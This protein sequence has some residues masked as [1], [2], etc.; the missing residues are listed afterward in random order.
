VAIYSPVDG[1]EDHDHRHGKLYLLKPDPYLF[2]G[3]S[4]TTKSSTGLSKST[5]G[6]VFLKD[7]TSV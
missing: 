2:T 7:K 5:S 4:M 3:L 1:E 6:V